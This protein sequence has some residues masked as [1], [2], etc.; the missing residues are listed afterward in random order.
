MEEKKV[1]WDKWGVIIAVVSIVIGFFGWNA[2]SCSGCIS[3]SGDGGNDV[4][5][6]SSVVS[7]PTTTPVSS[8]PTESDVTSEIE[9][10]T[11]KR[12]IENVNVLGTHTDSWALQYSF[13]DSALA[14]TGDYYS[15]S[16][17][18][19]SCVSSN[20]ECSIEL[21]LN[22]Q[23]T[24]FSTTIAL[25]NTTRDLST[26]YK[27]SVYCDGESVWSKK[28]KAGTLPENLC[29]DVS[30]VT[31]IEIVLSNVGKN[32]PYCDIIFGDAYFTFAESE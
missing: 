27:V 4:G 29:L 2:A 13:S 26:T 20:Q 6:T 30:G 28:Y 12:Y 1:N 22:E 10:K 18:L 7:K 19:E 5:I 21:Y 9:Q 14:N 3:C 15:H 32:N 16:L 25:S 31:V 24:E 23:F 8:E 17:I 11:G